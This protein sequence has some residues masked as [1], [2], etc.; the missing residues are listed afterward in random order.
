MSIGPYSFD[1]FLELVRNFHG[2]AAPG[3]VLGGI[4]V[5]AAKK[6]LAPETLFDAI[7]ETPKC[8]P[9]AIQLLTPCTI[10]NGWLKIVHLG[11][12]ALSLYDKYEG[13]GIRVF[14]DP[15]KLNHYLEIKDWLLG[16]KSKEQ[17]NHDRLTQQ[18]EEAGE[19][20]LGFRAIQVQSRLLGRKSKSEIIL[21]SL[22]GEAYP[23]QDGAICRACQGEG[24]YLE[25]ES[26]GGAVEGLPGLMA[27]SLQ[28]AVGK[29]LLHDMTRIVPHELKRAEF[30]AGQRL[31][32]GD[33]CR[34]QRMGRQQ[35][36][37]EPEG[38]Q[39]KGWVHENEAAQAFAAAMAGEGV[40]G[41]GEP[42][43]GKVTLHAGRDGLL[44]VERERLE[45]FNLVPDVMCASRQNY[46]VVDQD[47]EVAGTRAIP[48]YLSALHFQQAMSI[49]QGAHFFRCCPLEGPGSVF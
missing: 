31:T 16:L 10:G 33:V 20:I 8:L 32:A 15:G 1:Q 6:R 36:F 40:D 12:Y 9:D 21:C 7:S 4:M 38:V 47:K 18:I 37:V 35:V 44:V 41:S 48:L 24:P 14:L 28:A 2:Y 22:C 42:S 46:T 17:Q 25:E 27:V 34:L 3:V 30:K 11:R 23:R 19:E 5:E 26:P 13:T 29:T 49:L 43:E 39:T 45:Q